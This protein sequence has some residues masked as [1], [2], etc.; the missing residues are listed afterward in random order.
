[1]AKAAK[2][3]KAT[4]RAKAT[5]V[6]PRPGSKKAKL[7]AL[8]QRTGGATMKEML[9]SIGWK[10]CRGTLGVV[11]AAAKMKLTMVKGEDGKASRWF[12]K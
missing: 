8:V 10:A 6:L 9:S 5:N 3:K 1:M 12:A 11:V 7:L 4:K 2:A